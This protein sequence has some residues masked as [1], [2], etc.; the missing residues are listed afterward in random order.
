MGDI[1]QEIERVAER[2]SD[3][4]ESVKDE[5]TDENEEKLKDTQRQA[6][7]T[8]ELNNNVATGRL[9]E[10]IVYQEDESL[11]VQ[12]IKVRP[13][14]APYVEKGTGM[15]GPYPS[16]SSPPFEQI[17]LWINIKGVIPRKYYSTFALA[18]AI[19]HNIEQE[20]TKPHPF[21]TPAWKLNKR[22]LQNSLPVALKR[23]VRNA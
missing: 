6:R 16:P 9:M 12:R 17:L 18:E 23:G 14:Y 19:S 13:D 5:V 7:L 10:G 21:I 8:L 3:T 2:V 11:G 15:Y 4:P 20:G 1:T 22:R